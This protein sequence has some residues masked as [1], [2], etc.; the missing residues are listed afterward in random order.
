L[1]E[2]IGTSQAW[3]SSADNHDSFCVSRHKPTLS[4]FMGP[5]I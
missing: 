5:V 2:P 1:L 4:K 3:D